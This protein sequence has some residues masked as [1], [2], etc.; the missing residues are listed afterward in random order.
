[1]MIRPRALGSKFT[2]LL[3]DHG[4]GLRIASIE[5]SWHLNSCLGSQAVIKR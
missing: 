3:R 1:M 2:K 4:L 5:E